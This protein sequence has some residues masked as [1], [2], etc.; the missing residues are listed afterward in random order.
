MDGFG[1]NTFI[2]QNK[3][4]KEVYVKFN[5]KTEEGA[6]LK[7]RIIKAQTCQPR[8]M[9]CPSIQYIQTEGL[10]CRCKVHE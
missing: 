9:Q 3:E 2:L 7:T 10:H 4:G 1:V 8:G 5:W 6:F